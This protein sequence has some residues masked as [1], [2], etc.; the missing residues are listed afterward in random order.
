MS[1]FRLSALFVVGLLAPSTDADP[2]VGHGHGALVRR[3]ARAI[4]GNRVVGAEQRRRLPGSDVGLDTLDKCQELKGKNYD[5]CVEAWLAEIPPPTPAPMVLLGEPLPTTISDIMGFAPPPSVAS[6]ESIASDSIA[7]DDSGT[8]DEANY[9]AAE[10]DVTGNGQGDSID[11]LDEVKNATTSDDFNEAAPESNNGDTNVNKVESVL[12]NDV[13]YV[14]IGKYDMSLTIYSSPDTLNESENDEKNYSFERQYELAA[15]TVH[16]RNVYEERCKKKVIALKINLTPV[17]ETK[18]TQG[19]V[20]HSTFDGT[21]AFDDNSEPELQSETS[22]AFR[23]KQKQN[24]LQLF[25]GLYT[26]GMAVP[27]GSHKTA[28]DITTMYD[29]AVKPTSNANGIT[30]EIHEITSSDSSAENNDTTLIVLTITS[31]VVTVITLSGI[32][33]FIRRSLRP[34]PESKL[35][36]KWAVYDDGDKVEKVS[37][38][39]EGQDYHDGMADLSDLDGSSTAELEGKSFEGNSMQ[40]SI[41]SGEGRNFN[42]P[43]P[44]EFS[45]SSP[46]S[47]KEKFMRLNSDFLNALNDNASTWS[48]T[49]IGDDNKSNSYRDGGSSTTTKSC[50]TSLGGASDLFRNVMQYDEIV[51]PKEKLLDVPSSFQGDV[52]GIDDEY[53]GDG[54]SFIGEIHHGP[55]SSLGDVNDLEFEN[56]GDGGSFIKEILSRDV[57]V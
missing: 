54:S 23:G 29:V 37:D 40:S 51:M 16:L 11:S 2:F 8:V 38:N 9:D 17:G 20:L 31:V 7:I 57:G 55:S 50:G 28:D 43:F 27:S 48:F 35:S 46:N 12:F 41:S 21:V 22:F 4:R 6:S 15:T 44:V 34:Q 13:M 45:S 24:F 19:I 52:S 39:E 1:W 18:M 26:E 14:N 42:L 53:Y 3:R 47:E 10:N 33:V 36:L 56:D 32:A 5:D 25:H 30:D 49:D